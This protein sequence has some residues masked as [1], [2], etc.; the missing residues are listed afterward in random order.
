MIATSPPY[1]GAV[2]DGPTEAPY[3]DTHVTPNPNAPVYMLRTIQQ[4]HVQLSSLA[5]QK[6][7]FLIGGLVVLLGIVVSTAQEFPTPTIASLGITTLLALWFAI[8]AVMPRK[9]KPKFDTKPNTLFFGV[10]QDVSEEE[11]ISEHI[12]L[13][14][15]ERA[16]EEAML[17]DI[18]QMGSYLAATKYRFLRYAYGTSLI[19]GIVTI[20]VAIL[21]AVEVF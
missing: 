4:H 16:I 11:F 2:P 3:D 14:K 19:G 17:R 9:Y 7:G 8:S 18:H 10:F 1:G 20:L 13:M 5:D 15:S 21:E 12:E 6:A